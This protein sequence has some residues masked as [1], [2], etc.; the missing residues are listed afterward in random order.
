MSKNMYESSQYAV[1]LKNVS[2][3][4]KLQKKRWSKK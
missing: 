3:I 1:E 4:Y 2:K